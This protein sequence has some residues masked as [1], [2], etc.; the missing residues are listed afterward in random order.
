M[1]SIEI[2]FQLYVNKEENEER[3]GGFLTIRGFSQLLF[4]LP[5]SLVHKNLDFLV[6]S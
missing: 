4:C 3:K 5:N 6:L 1:E 2:V